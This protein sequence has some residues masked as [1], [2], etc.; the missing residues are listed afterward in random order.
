MVAVHVDVNLLHEGDMCLGAAVFLLVIHVERNDPVFRCACGAEKKAGV[1][2]LFRHQ[3]TVQFTK[4]TFSLFLQ[5]FQQIRHVFVVVCTE[6]CFEL[7]SNILFCVLPDG[8][9]FT[10]LD[11]RVG[12]DALE[13]DECSVERPVVRVSGSLARV[14]SLVCSTLQ[15]ECFQPAYSNAFR[16]PKVLTY[17]TWGAQRTGRAMM[18]K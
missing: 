13:V 18:K 12:A 10:R 5:L 4:E 16:Q 8:P 6:S 1:V 14:A 11:E 7:Y 2:D 9:T 17:S 15:I 3:V